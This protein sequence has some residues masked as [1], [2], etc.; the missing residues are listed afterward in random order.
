MIERL[1]TTDKVVALTF[2]ACEARGAPAFLDHTILKVLETEKVPYTIF[3]SGLFARRNAAELAR[4]AA[5]DGVRIENHSLD[6]P[7]HMERL[8][9]AA[10]RRE[11]EEAD[12]A[13]QAVTGRKPRFF[14]F[15]AGNYD[16]ATLGVVE[17][18]GHK[19]VHWTFPSGDPARGLTPE[20]L[21]EWVLSKTRPGAILIFHVNQRAP[22][23]GPALPG[24]LAELRRRGYRFVSLEEALP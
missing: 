4:L 16:A 11:V 15:P 1:P 22:A 7:Q 13:I 20:H 2:D 19:V 5:G 10:I 14:R 23:T 18:T 12:A 21:K 3:A 8:D 6:H 9:P 17:A 24:L